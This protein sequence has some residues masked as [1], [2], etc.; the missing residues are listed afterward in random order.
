M[1]HTFSGVLVLAMLVLTVTS[2]QAQWVFQLDYMNQKTDDYLQIEQE[3]W[4]PVHQE[5]IKAGALQLWT[6]ISVPYGFDG[7]YTHV[8][9]NGYENMAALEASY[10]DDFPSYVEAAHPGVDWDEQAARTEASRDLV[11]T[12]IWS[13]AAFTGDAHD[14]PVTVM[15]FMKV[16]QGGNGP[17]LQMERAVFQPIQEARI[18]DNELEAWGIYSLW[19]PGGSDYPYNYVAANWYENMTQMG[20]GVSMSDR[21]AAIHP[22]MTTDQI[23]HMVNMTRQLVRSEL[24]YTV[25]HVHATDMEASE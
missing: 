18:A 24:W 25:D 23:N 3:V 19:F 2:V 5:R 11:K 1:K 14:G 4:K 17:Y 20:G 9:I 21:V 16:P 12:E 10:G 8:T 7:S 6:L 15:A 22:N 13:G